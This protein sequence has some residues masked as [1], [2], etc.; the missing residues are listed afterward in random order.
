MRA[1]GIV[2]VL[3]SRSIS[4][5]VGELH[6]VRAGR[7]QNQELEPEPD[8][9]LHVGHR[10]QRRD[11]RRDGLVR[12]RGEMLLVAFVFREHLRQSVRGIVALSR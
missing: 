9:V 5:Q 6:F 8:G 2:H 3:S 4:V 11:K 10:L 1:P 7:R 12:Q